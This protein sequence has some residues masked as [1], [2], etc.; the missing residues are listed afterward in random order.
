MRMTSNGSSYSSTIVFL[1]LE[2]TDPLGEKYL[3]VVLLVRPG[4]VQ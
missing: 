2:D 3:G 4:I 1:P